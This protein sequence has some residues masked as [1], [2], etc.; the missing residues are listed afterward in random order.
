MC[1]LCGTNAIVKADPG[2][3]FNEFVGCDICGRYL[4]SPDAKHLFFDQ[5]LLANTD[6]EKIVAFIKKKNS[7][8][9]VPLI[10]P[11]LITELTGVDS[12]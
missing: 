1:Y 6:K 7:E 5:G 2:N 4:V 9:E 12:K 10:T 8:E 11:G 3:I